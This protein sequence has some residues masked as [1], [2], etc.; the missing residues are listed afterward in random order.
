MGCSGIGQRNCPR[1]WSCHSSQDTH[2]PT[3]GSSPVGTFPLWGDNVE[4]FVPERFAGDV[5]SA[6][7]PFGFCGGRVCPGQHFACLETATVLATLFM[8]FELELL[9]NPSDVSRVYGLVTRTSEH[10]RLKVSLKKGE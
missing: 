8:N 5:P 1:K 2:C 10:I 4:D 7:A 6:F 3:L 9:N